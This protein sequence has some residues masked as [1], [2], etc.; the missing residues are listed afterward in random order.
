MSKIEESLQTVR[1]LNEIT[2]ES[3]KIP[4]EEFYKII[5]D[6]KKEKGKHVPDEVIN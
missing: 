1:T 3:I 4:K 6:V 5:K 2:N